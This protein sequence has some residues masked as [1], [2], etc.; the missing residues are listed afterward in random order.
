[1][2]AFLRRLIALLAKNKLH[3]V[4]LSLL[5][6][7]GACI[8]LVQPILFAW[9]IDK[10]PSPFTNSAALDN[11]QLLHFII[12][13]I[14]LTLITQVVY[15]IVNYFRVG[16]GRTVA[17]DASN[18]IRK[19][20][21]VHLLHLPYSYFLVHNSGG[22]ANTWLNDVDDIDLSVSGFFEL[23]LSSVCMILCY[24]IALTIWNPLIGILALVF[25][26]LTIFAQRFLRKKVATSSRNKVDLR[27]NMLSDV[28]EAI[29]HNNVV[30]TFNLEDPI[31]THLDTLSRHYS[32]NDIYLETT[33]SALRSSASI[34]LIFTQY[35]FFVIGAI[36]VVSDGLSLGNFIGQ[37][38]M[39][40]QLT[41]P[42][43]ELLN[44]S[45]RLHQ[46]RASLH[47]VDD[48]LAMPRESADNDHH[49]TTFGN[50][51]SSD[52]GIDLKIE[53]L[54]F[55]YNGYPTLFHDINIHARPGETI[56]IVGPSGSGKTTL[57]HLILSF[58]DTYSGSISF[59]GI[60]SRQLDLDF[61]RQHI[62]IVFQ[63]QMLF[64]RSVRENVLMGTCR[65]DVSD[66]EIWQCLQ[67]AYA[68]EFVRDLENGL[69]TIIGS[70]GIALSGG[71]RQRIAIARAILKNPPLLLL[72]EATSALDSI[73]EKNIQH[74][75]QDLLQHR[76]SIII[77]HRLST[78]TH[79][80]RIIVIDNGRVVEQGSHQELLISS[81]MYRAL[82]DTQVEG[83]MNWQG[84]ADDES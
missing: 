5:T 70:N 7:A 12:I 23:G 72:D 59:N 78:I 58:F 61:M 40:V 51:K 46:S 28:S 57:F 68:D 55:H 15:I 74:A 53:Q 14:V 36:L 81:D 10:L 67:Q 13:F 31:N 52:S 22:Q 35:A 62:G 6:A 44:Y 76:T 41:G 3:F 83:F 9:L 69:D 65:S 2:L 80:D 79:A 49:I 18:S 48:I 50:D 17:L 82:Y 25:M 64:N 63:E 56:A 1:M 26:P 32:D 73:S 34:I 27:E 45:N 24:G 77:A 20:F 39:L 75:L 29:S 4:V 21:F 43:N 38:F 66:Q 47:R 71:Q 19:K 16:L 33:Q 42:M 8:N 30:K 84:D 54:S 37:F 11:D 60:D